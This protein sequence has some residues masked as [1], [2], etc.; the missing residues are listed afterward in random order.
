MST[1]VTTVTLNMTLSVSLTVSAI[2]TMTLTAYFQI[3]SLNKLLYL[4]FGFASY[5]SLSPAH[6]GQSAMMTATPLTSAPKSTT[7]N[8]AVIMFLIL[9]AAPQDLW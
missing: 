3:L 2:A 4:Y 6:S 9:R 5:H 7:V 1:D 8:T